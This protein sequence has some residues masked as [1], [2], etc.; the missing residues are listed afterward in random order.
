MVIVSSLP[1]GRVV[2][3]VTLMVIVLALGSRSIAAVGG[4]AVVLH[5]E[6]EA[7]RSRGRWRWRPGVKTSL[8]AAMS[9]TLIDWPAVTPTPFSVSAPAAGSVVIFTLAKALAG[10]SF[11][12]LKPKSAVDEGVGAVFQRGDRVV[13]ARRA[14]R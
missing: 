12:S 10:L 6:G 11:G 5:L 14:R 7:R 3:A 1:D 9:A 4:A 2:D 8:P 13:A